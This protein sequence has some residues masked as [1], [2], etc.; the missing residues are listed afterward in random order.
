MYPTYVYQIIKPDVYD[1]VPIE[2]SHQ[3][4]E[5]NPF[6]CLVYIGTGLLNT[7]FRTS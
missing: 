5:G 3:V 4:R 6:R 1:S 7:A 2:R